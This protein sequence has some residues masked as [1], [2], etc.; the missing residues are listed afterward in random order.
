M[1]TVRI[2]GE[3]HPESFLMGYEWNEAGI[4]LSRR[5]FWIVHLGDQDDAYNHQTYCHQQSWCE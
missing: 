3:S 2:I 4:L 5:D 1:F